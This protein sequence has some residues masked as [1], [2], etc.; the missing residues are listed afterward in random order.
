MK[1]KILGFLMM[2]L[3]TAVSFVTVG[4]QPAMAIGGGNCGADTLPLGFKP[5]FAG[6]CGSN[7]EVEYPA[8]GNQEELTT[9]VWI[10]VLNV[11]FD[12]LLV[13]G[14]LAVGFIVWGGYQ[15]IMAQGDPGRAARG[16]RTLTSAIIGLVIVLSASVLVNTIRVVLSINHT[17][18]W[19]QGD[20]SYGNITSA[21]NWAYSVAGIVAVAF[22]VK[23][24]I[25]Y[26]LSSG[27]PRKTHQATM[28]I[29]YAIVGL[30]IVLLA[31][32]I[33]NFILQS[34]NG[35]LQEEETSYISEGELG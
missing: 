14:Y 1:R 2:V 3:V 23:G 8:K 4:S 24:A 34:M 26:F 33:T 31:A 22:I 16:Q 17:D 9:F 29:I 15:Y 35:A 13:S 18:T 28:T 12:L 19:N 25:T 30:V 6:L 32:A 20:I 7:N 5:W 21:F 10:I 11:L 27:D